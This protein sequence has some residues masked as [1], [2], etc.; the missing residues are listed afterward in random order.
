MTRHD[1]TA[2]QIMFLRHDLD[3]L[4]T[5]LRAARTSRLITM[6]VRTIALGMLLGWALICLLG[7]A[8]FVVVGG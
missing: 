1:P 8:T 2:E 6:P 5:E 3:G 7:L 4:R